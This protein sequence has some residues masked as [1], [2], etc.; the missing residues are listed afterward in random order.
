MSFAVEIDCCEERHLVVVDLERQLIVTPAHPPELIQRYRSLYE[1]GGE[2]VPCCMLLLAWEEGLR[3]GQLT[4]PVDNDQSTV[5]GK[6][7]HW[8]DDT[9]DTWNHPIVIVPGLK[10]PVMVGREEFWIGYH[11]GQY[12]KNPRAFEAKGG[13]TIHNPATYRWLIGDEWLVINWFA[14]KGDHLID[15][16][17]SDPNWLETTPEYGDLSVGHRAHFGQVW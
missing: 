11:R 12:L 13:Q 2:P 5:Q 3:P 8:L 14:K 4:L 9:L 1:L 7:R 10:S 17:P 6:F 16:V 15:E